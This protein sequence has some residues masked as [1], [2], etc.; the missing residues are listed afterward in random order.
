ME[1][2]VSSS[3]V[4]HLSIALP[5]PKLRGVSHQIAFFAVLGIAPL[6]WWRADNGAE[7]LVAMIYSISMAA[8]FGCSAL[9]HRGTWSP[10]VLPWMRRLDHSMIFVFI[11]GTYT[12]MVVLTSLGTMGS[13]VLTLVWVGA[14]AGVGVTM[15]WLNA[16]RWVTAACYLIV[17]WTAVLA[18]PNLWHALTAW[19]FALLIVGG[20]IFTAGAVI[21]ARKRPD[22]S[23]TIFGYHELFHALVITAVLCHLVLIGSLIG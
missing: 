21:Y 11:A 15:L 16:P 17:G 23:P 14:A 18:L 20:L 8:M 10:R 7:I 22:P 1:F 3:A 6:L 13:V 19:R 2:C 4:S 12:P 9:L 5:K